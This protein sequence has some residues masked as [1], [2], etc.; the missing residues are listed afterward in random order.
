MTDIANPYAKRLYDSLIN[1]TDQQTAEEI[2]CNIPLSKTASEK[3]KFQWAEDICS[4]LESRFDDETIKSIRMGCACGPSQGRMDEMKRIYIS[5]AGLTEFTENYNKANLGSTAW[6]EGETIYFS[7]PACYCSCVKKTNKPISKTWCY[8]TL[9]YTK[10]MFDYVLEC[11]T[12]VEL[13]ES[14]KSGGSRCV[15]RIKII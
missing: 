14:I 6:H 15:M 3:K 12:D 5:S 1:K 9:G 13:V 4:T 11:N 8:C 2:V 7:Y 10:R